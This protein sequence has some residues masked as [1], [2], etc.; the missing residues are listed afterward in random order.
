[1]AQLFPTAIISGRGREKVQ[2]FVQLAELYY[3]GRWVRLPWA[4][5]GPGV[6]SQALQGAGWPPATCGAPFQPC[7]L[8]LPHRT[9]PPYRPLT[10]C[11]HGMDIVGPDVEGTPHADLAFQPA[12]QYEPLMDAVYEVRVVLPLRRPRGAQLVVVASL[13]ASLP[14]YATC[15]LPACRIVQLLVLQAA[16]ST[17]IDLNPCSAQELAAGVADI[18]GSSVEH[19]KFCVSVHFRNCDPDDYPAGA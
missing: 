16:R 14:G 9:P 12:A 10:V 6:S 13:P 7:R 1:M 3:A 5:V 18:T 17:R 2:Q 11:S 19:N 4:Q 8:S 15:T